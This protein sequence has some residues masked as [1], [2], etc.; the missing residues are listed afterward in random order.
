MISPSSFRPPFAGL[1][2]RALRPFAVTGARLQSIAEDLN[3]GDRVLL[4]IIYLF[5]L[6]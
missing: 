5:I 1:Y 6:S 4:K 2:R 3:L